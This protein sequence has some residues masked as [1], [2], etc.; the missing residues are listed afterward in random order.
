MNPFSIL[1]RLFSSRGK[2]IATYKRGIDKSQNKDLAGAVADFTSVIEN[3]KTPADVCAMA[4]FNRAQ[5]NSHL[6]RN[7][8]ALEDLKRVLEM[9]EAPSDVRSA[10][11]DK[12]SRMTKGSQ[13]SAT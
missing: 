3:S 4:L 7:D 8:N 11:K 13:R 12:L 5:A 1:A 6:D 2:A 10:A 9:P